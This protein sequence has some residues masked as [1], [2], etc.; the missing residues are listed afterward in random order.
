MFSGEN[1]TDRHNTEFSTDP[2][3]KDAG[4]QAMVQPI[5]SPVMCFTE[6]RGMVAIHPTVVWESPKVCAR[7]VKTFYTSTRR[8]HDSHVQTEGY[9]IERQQFV[10]AFTIYLAYI[11]NTFSWSHLDAHQTRQHLLVLRFSGS[12]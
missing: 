9:A 7:V 3:D 2:V 8:V 6:R 1:V 5:R 12:A 11:T 10:F 4:R